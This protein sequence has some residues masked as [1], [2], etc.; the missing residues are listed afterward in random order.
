MSEAMTKNIMAHQREVERIRANPDLSAEA[1][2]RMIGEATE[3]AAEESKRLREEERDALQQTLASAE[4]KVLS[5]PYPERSSTA[6][7][8]TIALS[9]RDALDRAEKAAADH[10]NPDVFPDLLERAEVSGDELLAV[11]VYHTATRRGARH[12]ADAYLASRPTARRN[13]ER[14]REAR[15]EAESTDSLLHRGLAHSFARTQLGE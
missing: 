13:W 5:I 1:K 14:Y 12:V 9:Y 10:D 4:K 3:R 2:R 8:A 6:E 7:R 11:A 15:R